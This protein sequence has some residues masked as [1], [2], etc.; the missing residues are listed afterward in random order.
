MRQG[1]AIHGARR[2]RTLRKAARS[3]KYAAQR[4]PKDA[5]GGKLK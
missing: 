1:C 2:S 3:S 4:P 5:S